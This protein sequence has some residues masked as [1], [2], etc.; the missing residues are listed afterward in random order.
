MARRDNMYIH[1]YQIAKIK[2]LAFLILS[3]MEIMCFLGLLL[4]M[5]AKGSANV[6]LR[7]MVLLGKSFC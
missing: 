6:P 4:N 7:K 3:I 2:D 1:V 5:K